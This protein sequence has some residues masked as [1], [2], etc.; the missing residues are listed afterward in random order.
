MQGIHL[1]LEDFARTLLRG[2]GAAVA[3]PCLEIMTPSRSIAGAAGPPV[4]MAYFYVP[5]GVHMPAWRPEAR[6]QLQN[7]P[8]TLAALEP[9]RDSVTVI[10]NLAA[11]H[12]DGNGAAH[13]PAGGGFLVGKKCKHSEQPEV[14][15]KSV[16]QVV[17]QEIGLATP[18]DSLALG[19]DPGH[20]GDHGYSGTYMSHISWRS[21][22]TP[23]SL[24]LN[25]RLLYV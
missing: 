16:D 18:V 5:N 15:G 7:L 20:R 22:T 1:E 2:V 4:R 13:E 19:I 24:E 10:S 17:S 6:E 11:D 12:C 23:V 8:P 14:G 25:P 3:L 9:V 21:P